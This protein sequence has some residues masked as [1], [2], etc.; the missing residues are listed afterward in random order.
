MGRGR[1]TSSSLTVASASVHSWAGLVADV[2]AF[3]VGLT[4]EGDARVG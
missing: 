3:G 1:L 4:L 2:E